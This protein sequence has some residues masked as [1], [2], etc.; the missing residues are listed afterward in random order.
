MKKQILLITIFVL[1]SLASLAQSSSSDVNDK[2]AR[3]TSW[4]FS[5][6]EIMPKFIG[7]GGVQ[8]YIYS[9]VKYPAWEKENGVEGTIFVNYI[10]EKDGSV[11]NVF[12]YSEIPCGPG[13]TKEG[14]R[15]ISSMPPWSPG[16]INGQPVRVKMIQQ[17]KFSLNETESPA[18]CGRE[19]TIEER[20]ASCRCNPGKLPEFPGGN[21]ML[22]NYFEKDISLSS[23]TRKKFTRTPIS[24]S[25]IIDT[26]GEVC[27][28]HVLIPG[29]GD[30]VAKKEIARV[31]CGMP[32]WK[33]GEGKFVK[34]RVKI[35]GVIRLKEGLS[36][37][38]SFKPM[39]LIPFEGK[40][41][42]V[43]Y[44]Y[45]DLKPQP[46]IQPSYI[47]GNTALE[48]YLRQNL[49]YPE[50][51]KNAGKE[52][53]VVLSFIV[54]TDGSI[55][56]IDVKSEVEGAPGFTDEAKRLVSAMPK[57]NPGKING[58][59]SRMPAMVSVVFKL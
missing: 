50:A 19:L 34:M 2:E 13:F 46:L 4:A 30:E 10:I 25:F 31:I 45:N 29:K 6:A 48:D 24:F 18:I 23:K 33:S 5:V 14:I 43:R 28:V 51:E 11:S 17:I 35:E 58:R 39:E 12:V 55:N 36:Q 47:R 20:M 21:V 53:T 26:T 27:D 8:K 40:Q 59:I 3:D 22:Q 56:Y 1:T 41:S 37:P 15:V 57:W 42:N 32:L 54:D 7:E 16:I 38:I 52:G 9:S 44:T 49:I